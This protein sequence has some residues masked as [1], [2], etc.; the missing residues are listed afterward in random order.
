MSLLRKKLFRTLLR[1]GKRFDKNPQFKLFIYSNEIKFG[2][3]NINNYE[4]HLDDTEQAMKTLIESYCSGDNQANLTA[5][6]Y[7]PNEQSSLSEFIKYHYRH[8]HFNMLNNNQLD[9]LGLLSIRILFKSLNL[10][11]ELINNQDHLDMI[12]QYFD[13]DNK[14]NND[15]SKQDKSWVNQYRNNNNSLSETK[16]FHEVST[17]QEG[18]LLVSHPLWLQKPLSHSIMCILSHLSS[19]E[20]QTVGI[21]LNKLYKYKIKDKFK[22]S[23]RRGYLQAFKDFSCYYGML[24]IS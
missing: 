23:T 8:Q 21:L 22:N 18:V 12:P 24:F 15:T 16:V 6:L 20:Q 17:L 11:S 5:M 4:V 10:G 9:E 2:S 7:K 19:T 13:V 1:I 3:E 14:G